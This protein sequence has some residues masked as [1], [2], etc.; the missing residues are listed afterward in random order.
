MGERVSKLRGMDPGE[1]LLAGGVAAVFV[2]GAVMLLSGARGVTD[3]LG[4]GG[5]CRTN[6]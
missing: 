1:K 5:G 4:Q 3:D 2:A 6:W